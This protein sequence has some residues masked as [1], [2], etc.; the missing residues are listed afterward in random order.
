MDPIIYGDSSPN[1]NDNNDV[2]SLLPEDD[3]TITVPPQ[4]YT[5]TIPGEK[6]NQVEKA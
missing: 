2:E 4:D 1:K 6:S 5:D 3:L